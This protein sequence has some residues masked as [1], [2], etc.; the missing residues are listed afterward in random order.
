MSTTQRLKQAMERAIR[1][2]TLRPERGQR[3]YRNVATLK[4]G[5]LCRVEEGGHSLIIDVGKG[6]GGEDAGPSP[7]AVLRAAMSSCVAIGVR[8][9]AALSGVDVESVQVIIDTEIDARGQLG[10]SENEPAGFKSVKLSIHIASAA[11]PEVLED[12]VS[13]SL[14]HSPLMDVF[15]NPQPVERRI[16]IAVAN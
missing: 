1:T 6:L 9:W 11:P 8:Q 4:D 16:S 13:R 10:V 3:S 2:V 12:I 14:A 5:T 7:S 15:L